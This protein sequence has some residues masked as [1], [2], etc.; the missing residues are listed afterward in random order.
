[1][2]KLATI[3]G[4]IILF[5]GIFILGSVAFDSK[6]DDSHLPIRVF[7]FSGEVPFGATKIFNDTITPSTGSGYSINISAAGFTTITGYNVIALKNTASATAVPNI[8]VKSVSTSAITVN[9]TEF[10]TT[11]I[12]GISVLGTVQF[13]A[14]PSSIRLSVFVTGS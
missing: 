9:V 11:T 5:I 3:S 1:M 6:K 2:K 14:D 4:V 12:L 10:T 8:A 13:V 7:R